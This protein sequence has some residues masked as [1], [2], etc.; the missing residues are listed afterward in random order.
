MRRADAPTPRAVQLLAT[1]LVDHLYPKV[2][3]A[4][5]HILTRAGLEVLVPEGQTCC[6]QPAFN[7]GSHAEARM[8]ARHTVDVLIRSEAPVIVPSGS[9]ADMLVHHAPAL[10]AEDSEY[11]PRAAAV[12]ERTYEFSQF[13]V[14]VLGQTACGARAGE[15]ITY[16]PSCHGL[17]GLGVR[18]QPLALLDGVEN[19]DRRPLPDAESCCGFGGLFSVKM[20]AISGAMLDRKLDAIESSGAATVVAT[21]VSCLMHIAG[22]LRR[23]GS[24][25]GVCHLA[26]VLAGTGRG[27]PAP[28]ER[29]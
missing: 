26:E 6:G 2:G 10:L 11:G 18:E 29:G 14:D 1:C 15:P 25:I 9:C 28:G 16:H 24:A 3:L 8:M 17:R 12:A 19:I 7:A 21:D 23:R 13:L 4:V 22:G 27:E 20:S 5:A